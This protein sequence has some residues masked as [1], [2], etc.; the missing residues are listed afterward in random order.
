PLFIP[1]PSPPEGAG[2][3]QATP[4]SG[5]GGVSRKR[6]PGGRGLGF[7]FGERGGVLL[8]SALARPET[9]SQ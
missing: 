7:A 3:G 9:N 6:G 4:E 5:W 2:S 8:L 1:P